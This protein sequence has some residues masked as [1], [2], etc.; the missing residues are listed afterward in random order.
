MDDHFNSEA[1][2]RIYRQKIWYG[3]HIKKIAETKH[4]TCSELSI[5]SGISEEFIDKLWHSEAVPSRNQ[6]QK[7]SIALE[8]PVETLELPRN[9]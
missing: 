8:V 3:N 9:Y 7:L 1:Q 5:L 6:L 4:I 2:H